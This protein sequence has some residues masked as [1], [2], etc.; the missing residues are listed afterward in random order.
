MCIDPMIIGM[1]HHVE[2]L[3]AK[4]KIDLEQHDPT[5]LFASE[6]QVSSLS[7]WVTAMD[8]KYAAENMSHTVEW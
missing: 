4:G 6:K 1:Y 2:R 7:S 5:A 3:Q 8:V